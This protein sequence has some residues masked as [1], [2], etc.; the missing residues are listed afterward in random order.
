MREIR[1]PKF[2]VR[3]SENLELRTSNS[4]PSRLSRQSHAA[5]LHEYSSFVPHVR[6]TD[7]LACLHSFSAAY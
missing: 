5:I 6:T 4:P 3:S 2:G 7:A 1:D